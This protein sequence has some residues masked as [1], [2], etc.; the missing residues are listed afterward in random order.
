MRIN[1]ARPSGHVYVEQSLIATSFNSLSLWA[2]LGTHLTQGQGLEF[3]HD[4]DSDPDMDTY[5]TGVTLISPRND[6]PAMCR[7][8]WPVILGLPDNIAHGIATCNPL[9]SASQIFRAP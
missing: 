3:D 9:P 5:A 7:S 2:N 6:T 4:P 1:P 8:G